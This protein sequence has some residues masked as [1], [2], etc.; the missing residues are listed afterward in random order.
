MPSVVISVAVLEPVAPST[1]DFQPRPTVILADENDLEVLD[2]SSK[3]I[4]LL[5]FNYG[6]DP[7]EL[8]R[9]GMAPQRV[10]PLD[11]GGLTG[12]GEVSVRLASQD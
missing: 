2:D 9:S 10:Q 1:S 6:P 11:G 8:L 3:R 7:V 4:F 12:A 5:F